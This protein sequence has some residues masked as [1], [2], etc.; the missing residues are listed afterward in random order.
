MPLWGRQRLANRL[1]SELVEDRPQ[2]AD[3]RREGVAVALDDVVNLAGCTAS[4]ADDRGFRP[5]GVDDAAR[6]KWPS[7]VERRHS[8]QISARA[9]SLLRE[10]APTPRKILNLAHR[11]RMARSSGYVTYSATGNPKG[12]SGENAPPVE[13]LFG[14]VGGSHCGGGFSIRISWG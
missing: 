6:A 8:H 12:R 2:R 13:A 10:P 9:K 5:P 7:R 3:A 11:E 1:R 4:K 14:W